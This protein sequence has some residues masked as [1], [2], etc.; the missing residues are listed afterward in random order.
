MSED[1][2]EFTVRNLDTG[3][4]VGVSNLCDQFNVAA[5]D[6]KEES[7][8]DLVDDEDEYYF[9]AKQDSLNLAESKADSSYRPL[10]V[11]RGARF[12]FDRVSAAG[13]AKDLDGKAYTLYYIDVSCPTAV[14]SQWTVYRR[15]NQF[16]RLSDLLRSEGCIV[17]ILPPRKMINSFS[18]DI[19]KERKTGLETWLGNLFGQYETTKGAKDPQQFECM[20][21]FLVD[22]ANRPPLGLVQVYPEHLDKNADSKGIGSNRARTGADAKGGRVNIHSF[23]LVRVIGKGSFGKVTLVR[24]KDDPSSLYAMKVL[25]KPNIIK[26]KQV[27]HT[28]TERRVLGSINHPFIVKLHYAFQSDSKLYFVLD[29]AAGGELFYHL[30][31][32]KK[33]NEQMTRFYAAEMVMAL[34]ELHRHVSVD[35]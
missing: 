5:L 9:D 14:P 8:L 31:R 13:T 21:Q 32:M 12:T 30:S 10:Q 26:R 28:R 11:P 23:E 25:S 7:T 15:Y 20:K 35:V 2:E 34:D 19:I 3:E 29:Y 24:K 22:D 4:I 33:F 17:P 16:R 27:E 18:M 6:S 1:D